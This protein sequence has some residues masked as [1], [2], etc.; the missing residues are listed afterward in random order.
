MSVKLTWRQGASPYY[1]TCEQDSHFTIAKYADVDNGGWTYVAWMKVGKDLERL[2]DPRN[3][4]VSV[5][6][7]AAQAKFDSIQLQR[8]A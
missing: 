2:N 5:A 3:R 1:Q 4:E 6:R 7:A 8:A